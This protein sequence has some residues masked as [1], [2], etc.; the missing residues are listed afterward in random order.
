[1]NDIACLTD[2]DQQQ[3]FTVVDALVRDFKAKSNSR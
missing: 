1:M 2:D 3:V